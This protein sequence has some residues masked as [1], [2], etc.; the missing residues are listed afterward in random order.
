MISVVNLCFKNDIRT[1]DLSL[2]DIDIDQPLSRSS[3][4]ETGLLILTTINVCVT[5]YFAY[6]T[7]DV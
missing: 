2:V 1:T 3:D 5:C 7:A 4:Q 6:L